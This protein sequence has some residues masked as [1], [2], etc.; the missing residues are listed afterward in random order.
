MPT[1]SKRN[2]ELEQFYHPIM[3]VL[4]SVWLEDKKCSSISIQEKPANKSMNVFVP[5]N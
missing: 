3:P 5:I 2:L 1:E 4:R